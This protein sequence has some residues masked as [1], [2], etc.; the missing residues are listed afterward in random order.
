MP[1]E[2]QQ[3]MKTTKKGV[4]V[5]SGG[6]DST[7]VL[8]KM[9]QECEELHA[10]TFDYGQL[11]RAEIAAA[12]MVAHM[13]QVHEHVHAKI[14]KLFGS[15]PLTDRTQGLETY[16]DFDTMTKVIGS[17]IEKTFV[18]LRNLVFITYACNYAVSIGADVVALGVSAEDNAN[19]PDCR[20]EFITSARQT[21]ETALG[22]HRKLCVVTPLIY[23]TKADTVRLALELPGCYAALAYSHTAYSGEFPPVTQDHATVLRAQGFLE[24][25]VPDPLIARAIFEGLID[26]PRKPN[27]DIAAV[28]YVP[29]D[30]EQ[31]MRN[32][33]G[34]LG[35]AT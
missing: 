19:Y 8:Y 34:A 20:P 26:C 5:L 4:C 27:Y 3:Y 29:G 33:I 9:R 17:R 21:I 23:K 2:R 25:G 11:H 14:G 15:S 6:Q 28:C 32:L 13:A 31:S 18:P 12:I 7:T 1:E 30:P 22:G 24:A 35:A 10:I 16:Q